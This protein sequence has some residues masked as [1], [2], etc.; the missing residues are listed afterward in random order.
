[1]DKLNGMDAEG[2]LDESLEAGRLLVNVHLQSL[3]DDAISN[4]H[5][6][7]AEL[8]GSVLMAGGKRLRPVL[9]I[10]AYQLAGGEDDDKVMPMA[11]AFELIHTATLIHDDINDRAKQRRGVATIHVKAGVAKAIIVG[12]WLFVQGFGL[13]GRYDSRIVSIMTECCADIA[14]SEL[15]Q[16]NHVNNLA[17]TPDDYYSI[18]HGKTAGPFAAC[19][20][21][22]ALIAGASEEEA[23]ALRRFGMELGVVFQLVDDLLDILGDERMGKPRS[24]DVIEGKMTLPLIHALTLLHGSSRERLAE[25]LGNFSDDLCTE[26]IGLLNEAGSIDYV[27]TLTQTHL[28]RGLQELQIFPESDLRGIIESLA[29]SVISRHL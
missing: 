24:A 5:N 26:L 13:G 22:A 2:M 18:V 23:A 11:L 16:L 6:E 8:A 12:D 21:A 10:L 29:K 14:S 15:K 25:I 7:V 9:S 28:E 20:E 3:L 27:R 1:M 17:T 19:C 4:G